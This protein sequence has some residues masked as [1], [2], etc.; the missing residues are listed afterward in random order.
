MLRAGDKKM[1]RT[2]FQLVCDEAQGRMIERVMDSW[3]TTIRDIRQFLRICR[4]CI[5]AKVLDSWHVLAR[6]AQQRQRQLLQIG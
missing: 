4:I 6:T 1:A 3:R 2:R 5:I